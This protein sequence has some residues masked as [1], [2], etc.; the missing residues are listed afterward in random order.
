LGQNT[1]KAVEI[2]GHIHK[3]TRIQELIVWPW[4]FLKYA[5]K[6]QGGMHLATQDAHLLNFNYSY[7]SNMRKSF[8]ENCFKKSK[9][10]EEI[11]TRKVFF[12]LIT[13]VTT[14]SKS[15]IKNLFLAEVLVSSRSSSRDRKILLWWNILKVYLTKKNLIRF[16]KIENFF[17]WI[18]NESKMEYG[19]GK[20]HYYEFHNV[21]IQKEHQKKFKASEHQKCP[22]SSSLLRQSEHRKEYQN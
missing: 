14:K 20:G 1:F 17:Q 11:L 3:Y 4:G 21:K 6:L 22:F 18:W 7:C 8:N 10:A 12:F 19:L 13:Q 15:L 9:Q 2:V 5:H 16:V